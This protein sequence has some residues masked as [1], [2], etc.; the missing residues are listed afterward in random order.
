MV[1]A[2]HCIMMSL[3]ALIVSFRPLLHYPDYPVDVEVYEVFF[4]LF[5]SIDKKTKKHECRIEKLWQK[6]LSN[7]LKR[8]LSITKEYASS[9]GKVI[10]AKGTACDDVILTLRSRWL[11]ST[12]PPA[13]APS[14]P[15]LSTPL[16]PLSAIDKSMANADPAMS[17]ATETKAI[18][19][20]IFVFLLSKLMPPA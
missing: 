11:I 20:F 13:A 1:G 3:T 19:F 10:P 12:A 8:A 5:L 17:R 16:R 9:L 14:T 4:S 6:R 15:E 2:V 18:T 7:G